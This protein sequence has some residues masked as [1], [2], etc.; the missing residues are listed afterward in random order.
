MYFLNKCLKTYNYKLLKDILSK[1]DY[2]FAIDERLLNTMDYIHLRKSLSAKILNYDKVI[3]ND[4]SEKYK[5][6][7][8]GANEAIYSHDWYKLLE[9]YNVAKTEYLNENFSTYLL[10]LEP[11][12]KDLQ[13]MILDKIFRFDPKVFFPE[14]K[15]S[16]FDL[17]KI[18]GL[19]KY[20][21]HHDILIDDESYINI[22]V[23]NI[24]LYFLFENYEENN[25]G[26]KKLKKSYTVVSDTYE[27]LKKLR[28]L[29]AHSLLRINRE[30]LDEFIAEQEISVSVF[31]ESI[32]YLISCIASKDGVV[33]GH[34]YFD[35]YDSMNAYVLKYIE[36]NIYFPVENK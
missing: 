13:I 22:Y 4:I 14:M 15:Y 16:A 19:E 32:S 27:K 9:Y 1:S 18:N 26:E 35:L 25:L 5:Y 33:I 8:I 31:H 30:D 28:N 23:L 10:M 12:Y 34:E 20:L 11:I 7:Y 6:G 17:F 36:N 24:I 2:I 29:S 21:L 3:I